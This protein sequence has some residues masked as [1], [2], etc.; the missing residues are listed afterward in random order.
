MEDIP[1]VCFITAAECRFGELSGGEGGNT[2]VDIGIGRVYRYLSETR[3]I[4]RIDGEPFGESL[5]RVLAEPILFDDR[6][7]LFECRETAIDII[8]IGEGQA[9]VF[10]VIGRGTPQR[11]LVGKVLPVP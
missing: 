8:G 3:L 2:A 5:G 4:R 6:T 10:L 1:S 9:D 11:K 7:G